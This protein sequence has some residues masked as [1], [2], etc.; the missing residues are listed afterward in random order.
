MKVVCMTTN[1]L[2]LL[3]HVNDAPISAV[4]N[5]QV[6]NQHMVLCL[7]LMPAALLQH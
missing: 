6:L 3:F 7:E 5:T 1:P 4:T 2:I